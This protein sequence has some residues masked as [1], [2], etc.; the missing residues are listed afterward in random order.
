M[1]DTA[2][3]NEMRLYDA[4]GYYIVIICLTAKLDSRENVLPVQNIV[5][6]LNYIV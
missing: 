6:N 5:S 3:I 1:Y 2:Y 4:I